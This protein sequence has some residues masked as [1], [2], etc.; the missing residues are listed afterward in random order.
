V[1][2]VFE[3]LAHRGY[4]RGEYAAALQ[5]LVRRGWLAEGGVAG[6]YSVTETGRAVRNQVEART[7]RY[8]YAPWSCLEER[9]IGAL[10]AA[11]IRLRDGLIAIGDQG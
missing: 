6:S 7:D 5:D 4:C 11:L 2:A 10:H 3:Q 1:D 8:F 9:E